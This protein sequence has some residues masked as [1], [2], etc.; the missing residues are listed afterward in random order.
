MFSRTLINLS[1]IL[2][3]DYTLE[4]SDIEKNENNV[5]VKELFWRMFLE[6]S[7]CLYRSLVP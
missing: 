1:N 5:S 4:A 7:T 2:P 6:A 3:I